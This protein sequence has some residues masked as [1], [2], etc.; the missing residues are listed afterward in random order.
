MTELSNRLL[1]SLRDKAQAV[2]EANDKLALSYAN[3]EDDP[4]TDNFKA[5]HMTSIYAE[6][7]LKETARPEAIKAMVARIFYLESLQHSPA[8]TEAGNAA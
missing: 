3:G 7:R 5:V 8:S 2:I 6:Q 1:L 4:K